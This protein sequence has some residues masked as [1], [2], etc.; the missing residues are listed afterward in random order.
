MTL[1]LTFFLIIPCLVLIAPIMHYSG[2]DESPYL[3]PHPSLQ[4]T[5][6]YVRIT[7]N[8]GAELF[9]M[10]RGIISRLF[11]CFLVS[12]SVLIEK[13]SSSTHLLLLL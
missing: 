7:T 8:S 12:E 4:R 2:S 3:S 13:A 6:R 11:V 10:T 1:P 5:Q 9:S